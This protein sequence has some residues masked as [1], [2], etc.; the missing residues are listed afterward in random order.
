MEG[1]SRYWSPVGGG[2]GEG[3]EFGGKKIFYKG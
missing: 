3:V 2:G 1:T